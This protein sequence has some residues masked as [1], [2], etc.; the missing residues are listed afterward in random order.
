MYV[1]LVT[2]WY[3]Q[4]LAPASELRAPYKALLCLFQLKRRRDHQ[5]RHVA[6][7]CFPPTPNNHPHSCLLDKRPVRAAG[8]R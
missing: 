6:A 5:G 8:K 4:P 2:L 1:S 3:L 7:T